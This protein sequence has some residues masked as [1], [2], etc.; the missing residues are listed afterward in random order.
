MAG[1]WRTSRENEKETKEIEFELGYVFDRMVKGMRNE[2]NTALWKIERSRDLSPEAIRCM[3]RNC[4]ESMIGAVEKVMNGV[5]D[6]MAKEWRARDMRR[7]KARKEQGE[8]RTGGKG[9]KETE[10]KDVGNWRKG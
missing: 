2:M 1:R 5:S 7:R 4:L 8:V 9:K 10:R 3:L 6:G